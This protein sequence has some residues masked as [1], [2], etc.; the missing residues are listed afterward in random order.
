MN[1][2]L[3]SLLLLLISA[4]LF[5]SGPAAAQSGDTM[6]QIVA[7][8]NDH[9][10]LKSEVDQQ[11][12]NYMM[13][14]QQQTGQSPEF[15]KDLWYGILQSIVQRY[16]MYDQARIDS[17]TVSD[18]RLDQQID[19]Q[20]QGYVDQLGSE[21][22]VEQ[23]I[24]QSLVQFRAGLRED[25]RIQAVVQQFETQRMQ[26]VEI[27]RP[28]VRRFFE[29]IPSDSLPT[30]PEQVALSHIVKLPPARTDARDQALQLARQLRD[31][32]INHGKSLEEMARRYS[33]GP[34]ASNGGKIPLINIDQLVSQYSAAASALEPGQIS[35]VVETSFGFHVIRLN[36]K[37]GDQIDTN[38]ILITVDETSYNNQVA[39]DRL[40]AIRDS[41]RTFEDVTFAEMARRHSDDDN[42]ASRGGRLF[43]NEQQGERL[44]PLSQLDPA[45]YRIAVQL[46][47][48]GDISQP[49][50]YTIGTQDNSRR[51]Y[52]IVRL[53]R[54]IPEHTANLE[55]DYDRI[56]SF[57]LQEKQYRVRQQWLDK[58]KE[59]TY[60]NYKI[61]V[62]DD[63]R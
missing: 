15:S 54:H 40:N 29:N 36:K 55:Q 11:A 7:V 4:L 63:Y 46:G 10:I 6:D 62:P 1:R 39:I 28:E 23:Q 48:P 42:T 3:S 58:L 31:S 19:S 34:N 2:F 51:A 44:F 33:D 43:F 35:E 8:V 30:I 49:S 21:A 24:G 32:V 27:T 61:P 47:E 17:I 53:D 14:Q 16:V 52:R 13:R 38:Q 45:L 41:I 5:G 26:Q 50:S 25:Y 18:E 22:A 56:R 12:Q 59:D 20:I 57:A 9:I 60:I 37:S